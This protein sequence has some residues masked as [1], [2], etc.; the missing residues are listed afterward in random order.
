MKYKFLVLF[1]SIIF[2]NN[3]IAQI[4]RYRLGFNSSAFSSELGDPEI[5]HPQVE[6]LT[7]EGSRDFS[8]TLKIGAEG[9]IWAPITTAFEVGIEFDYINL[10]GHTETAPLYN[11]FLSRHNP[12]PD[13]YPYP[14][15]D[16]IYK[17]RQFNI[18]A[19]TRF[20]FLPESGT[21]LSVEQLSTMDD[22]R[23]SENLTNILARANRFKLD[24]LDKNRKGRLALK[25]IPHLFGGI[26]VSA[27]FIGVLLYFMVP[28]YRPYI[29]EQNWNDLSTAMIIFGLVVAGI[30][31]YAVYLLFNSVL[32]L[33]RMRVLHVEGVGHPFKRTSTDSDGDT[34]VRHFYKIGD[35]KF[36]VTRKAYS[37]LIQGLRYRAYYTPHRKKLV[38]IE[39]LESP[40]SESVQ[41]ADL[42]DRFK[43]SPD[44]RVKKK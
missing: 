28:R 11:F 1:L 23:A 40:L 43:N 17:T 26:F 44:I 27:L 38:N 42:N 32:D 4:F 20:Y 3:S 2:C 29:E 35:Q 39:A 10:R 12:L 33:L 22:R 19:T 7:Y 31:I 16:L 15:E 14:E 36:S 21:V 18:L 13:T 24:V 30:I 6:F 41:K 8:P 25:Q 34:T 37:A 9:E 5:K